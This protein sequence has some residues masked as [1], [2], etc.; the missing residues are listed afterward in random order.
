MDLLRGAAYARLTGP[1]RSPARMA[2][3]RAVLVAL[4]VWA[5]LSVEIVKSNVAFPHVV[6]DDGISV[7]ICYLAPAGPL[8]SSA[9]GRRRP[10]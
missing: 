2:L 8:K 6:D 7:L 4:L 5:A 1:A 9:G 3:R 10:D